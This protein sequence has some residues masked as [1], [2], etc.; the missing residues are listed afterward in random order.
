MEIHAEPL[1]AE[2]FAPFGDV[3]DKPTNP[4]RAYFEKSLGNLRPSAWPSI[5]MSMKLPAPST[6]IV[7]TDLERHEFSSQTFVPL[8][9][10]RYLIV[11]APHAA[12]GG[13]DMTGVKAFIATAEQG[14][15][16]RPNTWH[17]GLTVLDKPARMAVF[18][19]RDG[20]HGDEEF[21]SI[22][23]LTIKIPD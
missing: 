10:G 6:P 1:T 18:M 3:L 17:H 8:E 11:V 20:G 14:I 15:T 4:G 7:A 16:Y 23:P 2:A 21:V 13:P 5:S 22:S 19:W 12:G 9:A